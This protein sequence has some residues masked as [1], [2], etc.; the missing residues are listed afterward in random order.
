M[1]ANAVTA[2]YLGPTAFGYMYLGST[3]NS[4]GFLVVEWGYGGVLPALVAADRSRTGALLGTS[5]A[6]RCGAALAIYPV[7][8][9]LCHI[10]GYGYE[11][12]VVV[13]LFFVGYTVSAISNVGQCVMLGFERAEVAAYRQILEQLAELAIVVP[14][15]MLGGNL[16]VTLIGHAVVTVVVLFY[17]RYALR[18]IHIG[19]L[20]ADLDTL[21]T[22]LRRGTPFVFMSIAVILQPGVD[23]TFL[24]KLASADVVG[25]HSAARQLVGFLIFPATAVVGA[26]YPTLCRLHATD[27]D[28]FTRTTSQALGGISLMVIPVALGCFLYPDIGIAFYDRKTFLPAEMNV[29]FLSLFVFLLYFT[30]PLGICVLAAGRQQAWTIVQS[31]CIVV[32]LALDPILVPW[33]QRRTGNGG[34]GVCVATV[35]SELI[36]LGCGVWL[37]PRGIFDRRFWRS[38]VPALASGVAMVAVART[39]HF[40]S[41]F[42]AAPIAVTAYAACLWI[43]GGVDTSVIFELRRLVASRLSRLRSR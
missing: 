20:S 3:F 43:T 26:L 29:R 4:F 9:G 5:I 18:S 13:S 27:L 40:T 6:W 30:M 1:L 22:L 17:V 34:L 7:L 37:A 25:W 33:F 14:I 11:V 24:S 35:V 23:A 31:S 32:S 28:A 19:R 8:I 38:M 42:V 39:L 16:H 21:K 12:G 36:V 15:L 41:S 2:R 10:L